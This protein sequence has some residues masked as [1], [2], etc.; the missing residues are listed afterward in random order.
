[1]NSKTLFQIKMAIA[2]IKVERNDDCRLDT[3]IQFDEIDSSDYDI[4]PNFFES[5]PFSLDWDQKPCT[6]MPELRKVTSLGRTHRV[7]GSISEFLIPKFA[8]AEDIPQEGNQAFTSVAKTGFLTTGL[9]LSNQ[10]DDNIWAIP[11]P[12][13]GQERSLLSCLE[14]G[15]N[16]GLLW[17]F[18]VV[19]F[20]KEGTFLLLI[21]DAK[22]VTKL[23]SFL[24]VTPTDIKR[25]L[26]VFDSAKNSGVSLV[27]YIVQTFAKLNG[28]L[29]DNCI[30]LVECLKAIVLQSLSSPEFEGRLGKF[31][32]LIIGSPSMGKSLARDLAKLI[33]PVFR[34]IQ[35]GRLTL[36]G[37]TGFVSKKNNR[38]YSSLGFLPQANLG[39][40]ALQ[41]F[42]LMKNKREFFGVLSAQL[43]DMKVIQGNASGAT[44]EAKTGIIID[45][46]PTSSVSYEN[47]DQR[48]KFGKEKI[49]DLQLDVNT[50]TRA[51][52][53]F[54]I[55]QSAQD[56]W[57]TALNSYLIRQED[58]NN[59]ADFFNDVK[60]L[61]AH[62]L[63][64]VPN[65]II[66]LHVRE[67]AQKSLKQALEVVGIT[68]EAP[69]SITADFL[70][71]IK[72][73]H[74]S[75]VVANAR[76]RC[77]A[78]ADTADVDSVYPIL[79]AKMEF[80]STLSFEEKEYKKASKRQQFEEILYNHMLPVDH[81][82][83]QEA[84]DLCSKHGLEVPSNRVTEYLGDMGT[85]VKHGIYRLHRKPKALE[86]Q[87]KEFGRRETL[88]P[89]EEQIAQQSK[90]IQILMD[91]DD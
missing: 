59:I 1:M 54:E 20:I 2:A 85:R 32:I 91:E 49:S 18:L 19:P 33:N 43:E 39:V 63:D 60:N 38:Y 79:L 45:L 52:A 37:L 87:E 7:C 76:S 26:A 58:K 40:L 34:E 71:R 51:G 77:E 82:R 42:H 29:L 88:L 70:L 61:I 83:P 31:C 10:A 21:L 36:P 28:L 72:R 67:H 53:I 50:I 55:I 35:V 89:T 48:I 74:L 3:N 30:S 27:E 12:N 14:E 25:A 73:T 62:L 56:R 16:K 23:C 8:R 11:L 44:L 75:M 84:F 41:D 69:G 86:E 46:N 90:K 4:S 64:S 78:I 24:Q 6:T 13:E 47:F 15:R 57:E 17:D 66:P 80:I 65:I 68:Q 81:I 5:L 9:K 22:P